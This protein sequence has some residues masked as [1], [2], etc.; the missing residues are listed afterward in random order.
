MPKRKQSGKQFQSKS[1]NGLFAGVD[2]DV[3]KNLD[4]LVKRGVARVN[5]TACHAKHDA[6]GSLI[7][8]PYA[9]LLV[10]VSKRDSIVA[11]PRA[12]IPCNGGSYKVFK[13]NAWGDPL[14]PATV[15]AAQ[16]GRLVGYLDV[17]HAK[18]PIANTNLTRWMILKVRPRSPEEPNGS[19]QFLRIP[20]KAIVEGRVVRKHLRKGDYLCSVPPFELDSG[21]WFYSQILAKLGAFMGRGPIAT[22]SLTLYHEWMS[23]TPQEFAAKHSR[24]SS[25]SISMTSQVGRTYNE[26][27]L[28]EHS[29]IKVLHQ[30]IEN[31][32]RSTALL[33]LLPIAPEDPR[34]V[35][36]EPPSGRDTCESHA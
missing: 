2:N 22:N 19:F 4:D 26:N 6:K 9:E 12:I 33:S 5:L 30:V 17:S 10:V 25:N 16:G 35:E 29:D 24:A 23:L 3:E 32:K 21:D 20:D 8:K 27:S 31:S 28:E 13:R 11:V 18:D 36:A 1:F 34:T 7:K 14:R 15:D